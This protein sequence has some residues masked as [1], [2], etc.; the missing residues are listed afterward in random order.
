MG[1]HVNNSNFIV[2]MCRWLSFVPFSFV[3]ILLLVCQISPKRCTCGNCNVDILQNVWVQM[4]QGNRTMLVQDV[5]TPPLC[6]TLHPGFNP[7][8]L[9]KWSLALA[10]R[11]YKTKDKQRYHQPGWEAW[12]KYFVLFIYFVYF[13][14]LFLS[15][16]IRVFP[17][18]HTLD[19]CVAFNIG[20]SP[21]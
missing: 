1:I 16:L 10:A 18:P 8:C 20:S 4:L 7:V 21:S 15:T 19:F 13:V 6:I 12:I 11:K 9:E 3:I 2:F 14:W 17:P 5:G